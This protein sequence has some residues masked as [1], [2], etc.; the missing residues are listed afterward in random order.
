MS[1]LS[2]IRTDI[3]HLPAPKLLRYLLKDVFNGKTV[4]TASLRAP[5]IVVLKMVA[6]I[7]PNT[8]VL[9]CQRGH[10]YPESMAYRD[11]I[12][13]TLGLTNVTITAGGTSSSGSCGF[14]QHEQMW[15]GTSVGDGRVRETVHLAE[16]LVP[17]DC[18]ISAVYHAPKPENIS[19]RVDICGEKLRV[20]VLRHRSAN[21]IRRFMRDHHLPF[22][23]RAEPRTITKPSTQGPVA[24]I[25]HF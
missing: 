24:D 12:I 7:D 9:F 13:E 21:D 4:V 19:H 16:A 5:S 1:L 23:P 25:Y 15:V 8:P 20:D 3:S 2:E 18:W 22:H 14:F 11:Q 10:I 17:Y 6:D